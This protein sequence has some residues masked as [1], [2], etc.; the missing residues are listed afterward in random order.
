MIVCGQ[1]ELKE[2]SFDT[3]TNPAVVIEVMS[4][5]TEKNNRGYKYFFYLQIPTLK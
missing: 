3:L 2:N 5:S 1:F 4:E